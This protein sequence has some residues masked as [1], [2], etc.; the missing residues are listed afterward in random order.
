MVVSLENM[1]PNRHSQQPIE[2]ALK[3][4][5]LQT[6]NKTATVLPVFTSKNTE[7]EI[8]QSINENLGAKELTIRS[9][10]VTKNLWNAISRL[11]ELRT[12]KLHMCRFSAVPASI[13]KL[14]KLKELDLSHSCQV[15][16][17]HDNLW[18]LSSLVTLILTNIPLKSLS[19]KISRLRHLKTLILHGVKM[20]TL[21]KEVWKLPELRKLDLE[22][23]PIRDIP[24]KIKAI[25]LEWLNVSGTML[26]SLPR[27]DELENLTT[28]IHGTKHLILPPSHPIHDMPKLKPHP[29]SDG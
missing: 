1:P 22:N 2:S 3:A 26:R 14:T 11:K 16:S 8:V 10:E 5:A 19:Q 13:G 24:E 27:F 7:A 18:N 12:L 15:E 28:L 6:K 29:V 4:G 9:R 25:A 20:S 17:L 23:V 21:P